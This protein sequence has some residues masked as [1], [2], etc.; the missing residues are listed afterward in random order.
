MTEKPSYSFSYGVSDSR[1]GDVKT[2]WEAK[3]GDTVKGQYSV[4]QP[5]GSTRTVEYSAGP[6]KGFTAI[7][8]NE[9]TRNF[10]EPDQLLPED[11]AMKDYGRIYEYNEDEELDY[12]PETDRKRQ[13]L[14]ESFRDYS[15][16][17]PN[18]Y[19]QDLEPSDFTHSYSIKHPY[20]EH[21][22]ESHVGFNADPKCRKKHKKPHMD[23]DDIFGNA[24]ESDRGKPKF[25]IFSSN[26]FK[27]DF[28]DYENPEIWYTYPSLPDAPLP[29]KFYSDDVINRP[30]KKHR[31]H[32]PEL[33][34]NDEDGDDYAMAPKKKYKRPPKD[35]DYSRTPFDDHRPHRYPEDEFNDDHYHHPPRP[36]NAQKEIVRKVVKKTRPVINLLD[37]FDI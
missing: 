28:E 15:N 33:S 11:K 13:S 32:K 35:N 2:V 34:Y 7:V 1:T 20:D 23:D 31:P 21:V 18:H 10:V 17:R 16:K 8:N 25:P 36:G 4:L 22:A 9:D 27:D 24:F 19:P 14:F 12:F 29:E 6:G 5:D 26:P 3:D 37:I 30:K